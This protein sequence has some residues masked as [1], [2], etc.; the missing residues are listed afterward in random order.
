MAG[1]SHP[2]MP[3]DMPLPHTQTQASYP[4]LVARIRRTLATQGKWVEMPALLNELER[5][6]QQRDQH[7]RAPCD[8]RASLS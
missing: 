4:E 3:F 2:T 6:R 8:A 5:A 7:R 1:M